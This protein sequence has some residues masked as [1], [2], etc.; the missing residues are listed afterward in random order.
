MDN[1]CWGWRSCPAGNGDIWVGGRGLIRFR[2][3]AAPA[4]RS[5]RFRVST[6]C[7]VSTFSLAL[8]A[9][10][11]LWAGISTLGAGRLSREPSELFSEADGLQSTSVFGLMEDQR[12]RFYAFT[13]PATHTL[14]EFTGN[15][16]EFDRSAHMPP[17]P[18]SVGGKDRSACRTAPDTGGSR[19]VGASS[20]IRLRKTL[21][22]SLRLSRLYTQR[23]GLPYPI[24]LR[25]FEDSRSDIWAGTAA[26]VARWNRAI[27]RWTS[28]PIPSSRSSPVHAVAEDQTGAIWVG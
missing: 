23:D 9:H 18:T 13:G 28:F 19:A 25:L 12:G 14:N 17:G 16:F 27:D 3:E 1:L 20:G 2:P 24:I 15:N 6:R 5:R 8:D 11:N 7:M 10:G 22:L 4:G 21:T 26:G